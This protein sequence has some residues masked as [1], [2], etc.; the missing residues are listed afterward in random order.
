[1][2]SHMQG[3]CSTTE[4]MRQSMYMCM[5]IWCM[6]NCIRQQ[7]RNTR[8]LIIAL[9]NVMK[10]IDSLG[11]SVPSVSLCN[12]LFPLEFQEVGFITPE[13]MDQKLAES[14]ETTVDYEFAIDREGVR[15]IKF[16]G[17]TKQKWM[18]LSSK[19]RSS[20]VQ[21]SEFRR[22]SMGEHLSDEQ[23]C[24]SKCLLLNWPGLMTLN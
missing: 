6:Y 3:D 20:Q 10:Y 24:W 2:T 21:G 23:W 8:H 12:D 14:L 4:P 18:M 7:G 11:V 15:V 22:V 16:D 5:F 19:L 13:N 17:E 9:Q 1:M